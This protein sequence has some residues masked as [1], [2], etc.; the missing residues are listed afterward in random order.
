MYC[1]ELALVSCK[2]AKS[3]S[4]VLASIKRTWYTCIREYILCIH[5][6]DTSSPRTTNGARAN[7]ANKRNNNKN[8]QPQG[9]SVDELQFSS[10]T[11]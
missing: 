3:L 5:Y 9:R 1:T 6:E 11:I 8:G 4:E 2:I 10:D 7:D